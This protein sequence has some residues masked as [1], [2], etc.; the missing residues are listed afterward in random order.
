[1][2]LSRLK[3]QN[4]RRIENATLEFSG[5]VAAFLGANAQGKTTVLEAIGYLSLGRSFKTPRDR[6]VIRRHDGETADFAATEATFTKLGTEH[7]LRIALE[8]KQKSVWLDR[9]ALRGLSE[10]WGYL[11]SVIFSPADMQIVQGAPTLRRNAL[12]TL[13]GQLDG[14]YLQ[15]L[16]SYNRALRNRNALLR[17]DV[18]LADPQYDAFET[19][20]ARLGALVVGSRFRL[21]QTLSGFTKEPVERL[22]RNQE[23]LVMSYEPGFAQEN[24]AKL[25]DVVDDQ[26]RQEWLLE[27]WRGHRS[28]DLERCVTKDGPHRDDVRFDLSGSDARTYASQGQVRTCVLALRLAELQALAAKSGIQPLLL[29]DDILG[30]LDTARREAFLELVGE[31]RVQTFITA[32]DASGI[33]DRLAIDQSFTVSDGVVSSH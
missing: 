5:G 21:C 11:P 30:E 25:L 29:L 18:D 6:E 3:I 32:T 10:M 2:A 17:R 13:L 28:Q 23:Q 4:F 31:R 27:Y 8:S 26:T 7:Q 20:M 19:E 22:S 12:D 15:A 14:S 9:K 1:M 33:S 24:A 16:S